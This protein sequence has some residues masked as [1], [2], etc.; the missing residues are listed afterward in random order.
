MMDLHICDKRLFMSQWHKF[1]T[2]LG[3][4]TSF[5]LIVI[6]YTEMLCSV[7]P[8]WP[9]C[10]NILSDR[11]VYLSVIFGYWTQYCSSKALFFSCLYLIP[12]PISDT[13]IAKNK[14]Q[15]FLLLHLSGSKREWNLALFS[16]LGSAS[17][18][19]ML[20]PPCP[21]IMLRGMRG[22]WLEH[23]TFWPS[24]SGGQLPADAGCQLVYIGTALRLH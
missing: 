3:L 21:M 10:N 11:S 20:I 16:L 17:K 19:W 24:L 2:G 1:D 5:I 15:D 8:L 4:Y 9:E 13:F 12:V 23:A 22:E 6:H 7:N 18:S 14:G